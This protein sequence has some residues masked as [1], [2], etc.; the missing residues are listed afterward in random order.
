MVNIA[1]NSIIKELKEFLKILFNLSSTFT[2]KFKKDATQCE[3]LNSLTGLNS[4]FSF[5]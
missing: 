1:V 5:S 4:E 2:T 3:F